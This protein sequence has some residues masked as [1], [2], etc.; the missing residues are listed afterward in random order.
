MILLGGPVIVDSDRIVFDKSG[1]RTI[2][3]MALTSKLPVINVV[4]VSCI[5]SRF[6][7]FNNT[8]QILN[9]WQL[10]VIQTY[11]RPQLVTFFHLLPRSAKMVINQHLPTFVLSFTQ[12]TLWIVASKQFQKNAKLNVKRLIKSTIL[13]IAT[14]RNCFKLIQNLWHAWR[15]VNVNSII[16]TILY[17]IKISANLRSTSWGLIVNILQESLIVHVQTLSILVG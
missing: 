17:N 1:G 13:Q 16:F 6:I 8:L 5:I 7:Q 4:H 9:R 12:N 14:A 11:F 3:T 10:V 2:Q 15:N